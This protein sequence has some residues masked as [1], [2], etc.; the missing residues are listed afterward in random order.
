LAARAERLIRRRD[1]YIKIIR[2][3]NFTEHSVDIIHSYDHVVWLGD[4]N[5]RTENTFENTIK[6]LEEKNYKEILS[7]DQLRKEISRNRVFIDFYE[8][9]ITFA[10][11]YRWERKE[12]TVSNK[13]DQPPSYTDR[14]LWHSLHPGTFEQKEY[15]SAPNMFGSDHRPVFGVFSLQPRLFPLPKSGNFTR[16]FEFE[17]ITFTTTA[18]LIPPS[19]LGLTISSLLFKRTK[20]PEC[21]PKAP[22]ETKRKSVSDIQ[23]VKWAWPKVTLDSWVIDWDFIKDYGILVAITQPYIELNYQED[24]RNPSG[25]QKVGFCHFDL[26]DLQEADDG[27]SRI[28]KFKDLNVTRDGVYIGKIN[29]TLSTRLA[30]PKNPRMKFV[31][32]RKS[33]NLRDTDIGPIQTTTMPNIKLLNI[34]KTLTSK[35]T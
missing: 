20:I 33:V 15:S 3:V 32:T 1:N 10:P 2:N 8:G 9:D 22:G 12:N 18:D 14:I 11:T 21:Q 23:S 6:L 16:S 13:K 27:K 30:L 19:N 24:Q 29:G 4:L 34:T 31:H 17:G 35:A 25:H 26:S 7:C 28:I 5:Y